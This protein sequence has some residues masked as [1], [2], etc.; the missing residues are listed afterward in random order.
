[1][2]IS[3]LQKNGLEYFW[4]KLKTYLESTYAKKTDLGE[5]AIP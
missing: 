3:V 4:S 2:S 5:N 1:M